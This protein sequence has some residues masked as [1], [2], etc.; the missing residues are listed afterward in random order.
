MFDEVDR[1]FRSQGLSALLWGSIEGIPYKLYAVQAPLFTSE[2]RFLLATPAARALR[3]LL[4]WSCFGCVAGWLRK[5][6][7]LRTIHLL[8]I[9]ALVW[10]VVYAFSWGRILSG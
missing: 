9:Y 8:P 3:F 5:Q 1:G 6:F 4:V 10:I 7:A 2:V